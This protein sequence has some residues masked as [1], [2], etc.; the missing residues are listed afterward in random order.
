VYIQ[1]FVVYVDKEE[2]LCFNVKMVVQELFMQLVLDSPTYVR[3][4]RNHG[5][6]QNALV[7]FTHVESVD[8]LEMIR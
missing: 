2:E 8:S 3:K 7:V 6:V 5:H 1:V 4:P